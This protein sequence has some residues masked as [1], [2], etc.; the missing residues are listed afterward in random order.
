MACAFCGGGDKWIKTCLTAD[1]SR[2]RVCDPCYEAS[3]SE[4]VIVPGA[5]IVTARC[6][7]CGVYGNP[8]EFVD[9]EPGGRKDAYSG[10]CAA[11]ANEEVART[12]FVGKEIQRWR[13]L[14]TTYTTIEGTGQTGVSAG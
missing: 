3:V 13:S 1:D 10:T 9:A 12:D 5:W 7:R 8:R 6:D 11:C 14:M 4:L 2:I